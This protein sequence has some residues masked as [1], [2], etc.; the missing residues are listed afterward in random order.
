MTE[1]SADKLNRLYSEMLVLLEKEKKIFRETEK[2]LA[3]AKAIIDPRK[4]FNKWL[5]SAEGKTWKQNLSIKMANVLT[6][7]RISDLLMLSF[8]MCGL[9]KNLAEKLTSQRISNYY[10]PVVISR[11]ERKL[12]ILIETNK[13]LNYAEQTRVN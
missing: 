9:C 13:K 3:K 12:L 5:Q 1:Q 10:I 7:V 4:E 11:L 6:V 2:V 8:I